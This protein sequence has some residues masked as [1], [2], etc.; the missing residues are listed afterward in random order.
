MVAETIFLFLGSEKGVENWT[1]LWEQKRRK[2]IL[3]QKYYIKMI[4]TLITFNIFSF[5]FSFRILPTIYI[6]I[7][8]D[9]MVNRIKKLI[10]FDFIEYK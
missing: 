1:Y 9:V 4:T 6:H 7:Y 3:K 8:L 10:S 2:L 5:T